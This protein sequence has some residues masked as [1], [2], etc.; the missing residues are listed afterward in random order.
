MQTGWNSG[1]VGRQGRQRGAVLILIVLVMAL[2]AAGLLM[3]AF[4]RE[5]GDAAAQRR[6]L[7][8][9]S[10]AREALIGFGI[11]YGRL[12]RPA[13]SATDGAESV[14]PCRSEA[15]C[16][17][18]LPWVALGVRGSDGWGKLL[19]YSVTPAFTAAPLDLAGAVATKRIVGRRGEQW[20]DVAGHAVCERSAQC[21]PAVILSTGKNNLGTS[22]AGLA[23]ASAALD[24]EDERQNA[25]A[26]VTFV[27]RPQA[28]P[29]GVPVAGGEFDDLLDWVPRN[30][31][32]SRL[33]LAGA[34]R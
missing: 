23:L 21:V 4:T 32:V 9:L 26:D 18:F 2:G 25:Q 3:S 6:S 20:W 11:R 33:S 8:A 16:T 30:L 12:P 31:L 17:G 13:S 34:G 7:Q 5:H 14:T 15:D 1:G 19:R 27:Q 28:P 24:N 22:V 29:G 10:E